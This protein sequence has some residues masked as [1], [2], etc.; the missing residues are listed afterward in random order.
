MYMTKKDMVMVSVTYWYNFHTKVLLP[1]LNTL[2]WW[3]MPGVT[4]KVRWP[5]GE[6]IG[7][8]SPNY[9]WTRINS[10]YMVETADPNFWY[11]PELEELVGKQGWDWDWCLKD[12]DISTNR[13]TI[14]FRFD[15]KHFATI[16]KLKWT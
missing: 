13:L 11:R 10:N 16:F 3:L 12:D 8:H 15:K 7:P 6:P 4:F 5:S 9:D 1:F 2:W 14:K